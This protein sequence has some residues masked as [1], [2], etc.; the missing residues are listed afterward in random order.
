MAWLSAGIAYAGWTLL[1]YARIDAL[2]GRSDR[3]AAS[4]GALTLL[5][6]AILVVLA[7][8]IWVPIGVAVGLRP[9]LTAMIQPIAQFLAAFPANLL[10]PVAVFLILRFDLAPKIWLSPLMITG[11]AVVHPFQRHRGR[12]RLSERS[13]G[14]CSELSRPALALVARGHAARHLSLLSSPARSP[15]PAAPG[16]RASFRRSSVGDRP[17]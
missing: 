15:P 12:Q 10:F 2:L 3:T 11:H 13:S 1:R 6:V 9:R 4:N 14:G 17:S 8:V 7:S 16:M 5:R